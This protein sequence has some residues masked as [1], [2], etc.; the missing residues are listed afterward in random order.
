[1]VRWGQ[2]KERADA[3]SLLMFPARTGGTW[4]YRNARR[5]YYG[6]LER[7]G[8][9]RTGFHHLRHTMATSYLRAGGDVVRLSMILGHT[10]VSTTMRYSHLL[11]EDLQAPHQRLSILNRLR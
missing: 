8:F 6:L 7:L 1:L 11:T 4:H 9:P 3:V 2:Q 10:E 5:A